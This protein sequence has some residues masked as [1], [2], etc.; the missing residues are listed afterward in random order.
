MSDH[1][2]LEPKALYRRLNGLLADLDPDTPFEKLL[3][4]FVERLFTTLRVELHVQSLLLYIER[5]DGFEMARQIGAPAEIPAE[6]IDRS[7]PFVQLLDEQKFR[8][9]P[10]RDS[11]ATG[12]LSADG[13]AAI[14]VGERPHRVMLFLLL[15]EGWARDDVEFSVNTVRVALSSRVMQERMRATLGEAA[16][17]Q[18]SLLVPRPPQ[19]G[20]YDIAFHATSAEV[21]GG[22]FYDFI[23]FGPEILGVSIGD[24]SGHGLP[25]ALLARDVVTGL[26]MGLEKDLKVSYVFTKLNSVVHRSKLSSRFVSLF[27]G[28]LEPN[29]NL[30]Y[31]N[32]GQEPPLLFLEDEVVELR[33]GGT[34][35][36]PLPRAR[37]KRGFAHVDR[38]AT[39]VLT[40]DGIT[41]RRG[42][43]G[44]EFGRPRLVELVRAH[45]DATAT[46]LV[47]IIFS[48]VIAFGDESPWE[49]DATL[50]VIKRERHP[51]AS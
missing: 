37:F 1:H 33:T 32:A 12:E 20:G 48:T 24:A 38:G 10:D 15:E 34:I 5:R 36:G 31:I 41:E 30:I 19:F 21:V 45:P 49:D 27:F 3:D 7:L 39:L 8:V 42:A 46:E 4:E 11:V 17:I 16:A 44:D 13:V 9:L 47:E 26:R 25:A 50:I 51:R 22:D 14:L 29:G 6:V 2:Q 40:T 18:R 43:S 28:E 23:P 35:V